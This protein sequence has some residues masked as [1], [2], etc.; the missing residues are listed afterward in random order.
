[1]V[2]HFRVIFG[3]LLGVL[4][5][6]SGVSLNAEESMPAKK[7]NL[8][9]CAIFKD[10]ARYLKEWIEYHRLLGVDHFYLYNND[11]TDAFQDV[12]IPYVNEG[13]VTLINWPNGLSYYFLDEENE[14]YI[15]SL[16]TQVTAY[17]NAIKV[18]GLNDTKWMVF[19]DVD[20]FLVPPTG[21]KL[22][23]ILENYDEYPGV[24]LCS[25][26]F[27]AS[28]IG[29]L[30][31]R[32]LV[33]ETVELTGAPVQNPQKAVE[34]TI[35]KPD[36]C[37]AFVWPPYKCLFKEDQKAAKLSKRVM[38]INRYVYRYKNYL[39]LYR[40]IKNKLNVDNRMLPDNVT[41]ELLDVGYEIE[42][43]ERVIYRFLPELRKRMGFESEW[44]W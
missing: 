23:T 5:N 32:K 21:S 10:E 31:K 29:T 19:L 16:S 28:K 6:V 3:L 41:Q 9:A 11:S 36:L 26:F 43:Q 44:A 2:N 14:A 15:W 40:K 35:V 17:E 34:K 30:P 42:D 20:E 37:T 38:R 33:I 4:V 27:D 18:A 39:E 1:M 13:I 24:T 7:Y 25:D 22:T 8:S 12:L